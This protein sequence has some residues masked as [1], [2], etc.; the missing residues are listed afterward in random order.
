MC[1]CIMFISN[2]RHCWY[3]YLRGSA[4]HVAYHIWWS[5]IAVSPYKQCLFFFFFWS[6]S[7]LLNY[8]VLVL[9]MLACLCFLAIIPVFV[10]HLQYV[11]G[12]IST[13]IH[14]YTASPQLSH[15]FWA[16]SVWICTLKLTAWRNGQEMCS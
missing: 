14:P 2:V 8:F 3:E 10:F 9:P 13:L 4:G 15:V 6:L 1:L 5:Y 12:R 16:F 7:I 11:V